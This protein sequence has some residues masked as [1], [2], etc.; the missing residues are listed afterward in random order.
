MEE[1]HI[2]SI[3]WRVAGLRL[4][5]QLTLSLR[6]DRTNLVVAQTSAL[7]ALSMLT[8]GGNVRIDNAFA[9][10]WSEMVEARRR[11]R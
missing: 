2:N 9:K 4:H 6:L 5:K 3:S 10:W 11:G 1:L 8:F 7:E